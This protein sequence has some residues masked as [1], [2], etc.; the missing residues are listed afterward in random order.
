M[1]N[2]YY[3]TIKNNF[4]LVSYRYISHNNNNSIFLSRN[5]KLK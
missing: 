5:H 1:A 4:F 3:F 2:I